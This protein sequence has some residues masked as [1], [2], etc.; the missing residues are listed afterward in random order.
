[1]GV[2]RCYTSIACAFH[3]RRISL[4]D[5]LH[6]IAIQYEDYA[7]IGDR[8]KL[9]QEVLRRAGFLRDRLRKEVRTSQLTSFPVEDNEEAWTKWWFGRDGWS[10]DS[11]VFP[12]F[13]LGWRSGSTF[14]DGGL[15]EL[16]DSEEGSI[17]SFNSTLPSASKS[18][19]SVEELVSQ[20]VRR[21]D[22]PLSLGASYPLTRDCFYLVRTNRGKPKA[23]L[24]IV[25]GTF[26]ETVPEGDLLIAL[27]KQVL[28]E[29]GIAQCIDSND[30][31]KI[32]ERLGSL[33]RDDVAVTRHIEG[34]SVK[35]RL[36]IMSEIATEGN[37]H[38]Y[39]EIPARSFNLIVKPPGLGDANDNWLSRAVEWFE[40]EAREDQV[41]LS[42]QD[43]HSDR[44]E[45]DLAMAQTTVPVSLL[46][47]RHKRNGLHL[48]VQT[49]VPT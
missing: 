26:F 9:E 44:V 46:C 17:A 19:E 4:E 43:R 13:V 12:D 10:K 37:P 49:E 41:T 27:W 7:Y 14:G 21:Y 35:P 38:T 20:S 31:E 3:R 22:V 5:A 36:R 42:I 33:R 29:A 18:L 32:L 6:R 34:A 47:I 24:S 45:A 30:F 48:V 11:G 40:R 8:R 25:H 15:L 39:Q 1:M 2:I 16:K 28:D 23:R